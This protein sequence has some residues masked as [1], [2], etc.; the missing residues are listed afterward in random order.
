[1]LE[2]ANVLATVLY[3]MMLTRAQ[4]SATLVLVW[5]KQKL[6]FSHSV[7]QYD[8]N[9]N[10]LSHLGCGV[11]KQ[12]LNSLSS[13]LWSWLVISLT[14]ALLMLLKAKRGFKRFLTNHNLDQWN[15]EHLCSDF[16]GSKQ[17]KWQC[18]AG[19]SKASRR[20]SGQLWISGRVIFHWKVGGSIPTTAATLFLHCV[21]SV[22]VTVLWMLER[23]QRCNTP[24]VVIQMR[25][26]FCRKKEPIDHFLVIV[27]HG[28]I[29]RSL[30]HTVKL[31]ERDLIV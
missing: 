28:F 12:K 18:R 26:A 23:N 22:C 5:L 15:S 16:P 17:K 25:E 14:L 21:P 19:F 4:F 20:Y 24:W 29:L 13:F 6:M 31:K 1:M 3:S 30:Y 2:E 10:G 27:A 8:A 9:K 7:F 11:N